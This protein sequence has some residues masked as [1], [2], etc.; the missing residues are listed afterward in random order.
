MAWR[1]ALPA[2]AL[3]AAAGIAAGTATAAPASSAH[4][5]SLCSVAKGV[6][7]D[8]AAATS[9][10]PGSSVTPA[11]LKIVYTKVAAAEPSM[12]GAAS[13]KQKADLQAVFSLINTIKADFEKANWQPGAI[14]RFVPALV[15]RVQR[16]K[17]QITRVR[18]Y[19]RA[20]CKIKGV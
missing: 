2:A 8:I 13:G 7:A 19:F 4:A 17:P 12:L 9:F 10:S 20:T 6:A 14:V 3:A 5:A 11:K 15:P 16:L 1:T 18:T